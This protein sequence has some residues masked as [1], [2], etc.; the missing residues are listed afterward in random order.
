QGDWFTT[1]DLQDAYFHIPI[2]KDHKK[3]LRFYFQ[4]NAYEYNVLPFGLSLAPRTFTKCMD[5]ALI[6][7]RRQGLR[8]ANYL[9]DWEQHKDGPSPLA[10]IGADTE[11]QKEL[12][13]SHK[14]SDIPRLDFELEYNESISDSTEA[15]NFLKKEQV[16]V[17]LGRRLLGLMAAA[18]Q[19]VP[20]G[21]LHMRPLQRWLAKYKASPYE[22]GQRMIPRDQDCLPAV[23]WWL[24]TPG[25]KEGVKETITT[26]ASQAGW[27]AVW[28]GN[29]VQGKWDA[30]WIGVHVNLLELEAVFRALIHFL[31]QLQEKQVIV[32]SDSTSVVSYINHQGGE[33]PGSP[34]MGTC[35]RG[36]PKGCT[37]AGRGQCSSRPLVK[38][39]SQARRMATSPSSGTGH[40]ALFREGQSR[41]FCYSGNHT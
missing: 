40:L 22:N 29:P 38:G 2:H 25:L 12:S 28:R 17:M 30:P 34:V 27:G 26:D 3:Y 18:S 5:A 23:K 7:L 11:Q 32:R 41:S 9:D 37:L 15:V 14:G 16:T 36:V 4:G 39:R 31:P 33:G 20:L 1:V 10:E 24:S 35:S 6:P 13:H 21:S 19:V 8:I